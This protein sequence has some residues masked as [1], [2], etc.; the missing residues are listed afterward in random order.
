MTKK[1]RMELV[2]WNDTELSISEQAKLLE[3]NRSSL[4]YK[5]VLPSA[6]E[7][8]VKHRIDEIYTQFPFF[9]S[10]GLPNY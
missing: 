8:G 9:G 6:E 3:I 2:D 5:L 1:E 7:V 4:Y 10:A